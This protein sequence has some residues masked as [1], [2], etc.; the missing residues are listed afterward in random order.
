MKATAVA[1]SLPTV[2]RKRT[3]KFEPGETMPVSFRL[4]AEVAAELDAEAD[5]LTRENGFLVTRTDVIRRW[6]REAAQRARVER[7]KK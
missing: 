4:D 2:G 6:L 5:R 3:K 1:L 7:T